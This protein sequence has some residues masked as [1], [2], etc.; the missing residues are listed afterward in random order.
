MDDLILDPLKL[1][2]EMEPGTNVVARVFVGE[3]IPGWAMTPGRKIVEVPVSVLVE[4]GYV[5]HNGSFSPPPPPLTFQQMAERAT[6]ENRLLF[7]I[8]FDQENRLR[9]LEGKLPITRIKYR[10]AL[11]EEWKRINQ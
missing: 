5:Y 1:Y 10:D 11:V 7:E 2:A 3:T 9:A 8:N 6:D 4:V